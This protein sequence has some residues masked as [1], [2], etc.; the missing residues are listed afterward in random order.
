MYLENDQ[1]LRIS[2]GTKT[3]SRKFDKLKVLR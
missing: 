3:I 1:S 2:N